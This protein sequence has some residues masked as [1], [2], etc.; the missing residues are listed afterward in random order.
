MTYPGMPND[1][2]CER[3]QQE[4]RRA[5]FPP[6]FDPKDA[7][8][9]ERH[10]RTRAALLS[11]KKEAG[12]DESYI[13]G[14]KDDNVLKAMLVDIELMIVMQEGERQKAQDQRGICT[15]GP[16]YPD[17]PDRAGIEH[18]F[19]A[20]IAGMD[21]YAGEDTTSYTFIVITGP[22]G[23]EYETTNSLRRKMPGFFEFDR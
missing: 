22:D 11:Y 2:A 19:L 10:N 21:I 3:E 12:L 5:L 18:N 14:I 6:T 1:E 8:P 7:K 4:A 9:H 13:T 23:G 16:E 20:S 15:F 17:H